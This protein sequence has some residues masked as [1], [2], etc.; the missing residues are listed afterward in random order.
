MGSGVLCLVPPFNFCAL[1]AP[2]SSPPRRTGTG[3]SPRAWSDLLQSLNRHSAD[4]PF[5]RRTPCPTLR[6]SGL[7]IRHPQLSM[8]GVWFCVSGGWALCCH[9]CCSRFEYAGTIP[10]YPMQ[11]AP[12]PQFG[13]LEDLAIPQI[14]WFC[15]FLP[16][17]AVQTTKFSL[18]SSSA[19]TMPLPLPFPERGV[20]VHHLQPRARFASLSGSRTWVESCISNEVLL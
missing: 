2:S 20:I 3:C 13:T 18:A 6:G 12:P 10:A 5:N 7:W 11:T 17:S 15:I 19:E 16:C 1:L 4:R 14:R 9:C 8:L